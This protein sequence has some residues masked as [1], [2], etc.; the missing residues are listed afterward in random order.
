MEQ[1]THGLIHESDESVDD[2]DDVYQLVATFLHK[3]RTAQ[4]PNKH[5][6]HQ[7]SMSYVGFEPKV[8]ESGRAKIIHILDRSATVI[9]FSAYTP[10]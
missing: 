6:T 9:G 5:I 7:T 8:P 1:T 3:R 10:Q 4:T 2:Y